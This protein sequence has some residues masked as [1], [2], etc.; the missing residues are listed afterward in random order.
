MKEEFDFD[1]SCILGGESAKSLL[2]CYP[3][4]L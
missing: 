1:S 2:M 4:V 3:N